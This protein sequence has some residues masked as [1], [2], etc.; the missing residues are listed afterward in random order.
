ML[1]NDVLNMS[2]WC[3]TPVCDFSHFK[4]GETVGLSLFIIHQ[5]KHFY[6]F[7][8][9]KNIV[10]YII[11]VYIIF[12]KNSIQSTTTIVVYT[13]MHSCYWHPCVAAFSHTTKIIW[14]DTLCSFLVYYLANVWLSYYFYMTASSLIYFF[15]DGIFSYIYMQSIYLFIYT[16]ILLV[17]FIY[18]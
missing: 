13:E 17:C 11:F 14:S 6:Y 16:A 5:K 9:K 4:L 2:T 7:F 3:D 10:K 15:H 12:K 1:R 18:F 8:I